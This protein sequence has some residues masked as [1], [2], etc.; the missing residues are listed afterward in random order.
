MKNAKSPPTTTVAVDT[1]ARDRINAEAERLDLSQRQMVRRMI[2]AYDKSIE[3]HP[4]KPALDEMFEKDD[5]IVSI[6]KAQG[7]DFLTP[8]LASAQSTEA[9]ID[10]LIELL[11][12]L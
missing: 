6:L 3:N 9:K 10:Q 12:Q 7:K 11:K 2:D 5:R 8:I 4:D 1:A